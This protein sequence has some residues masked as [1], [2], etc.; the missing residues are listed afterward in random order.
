MSE[1]PEAKPLN[2]DKYANM[3]LQEFPF[4][5]LE[6]NYGEIETY[7]LDVI[8]S[9]EKTD[10]PS[11]VVIFIHGGGFLTLFNKRQGYVPKF[12]R[13][14]TEAGYVVISPD[15][16]SFNTVEDQDAAGGYPVA[17]DRAATAIHAA[18]KYIQQ[19][20]EALKLNTS[21]IAIMGGS[22][23][24]MTAFSAIAN[25]DDEYRLFVNCWGAPPVL[26]SLAG[27]PPVL[28]IH[29]TA[30]QSVDYSLEF[31]IQEALEALGIR[32]ELITLVDAKH[33]PTKRFPEY[34]P[35]ILSYLEDTMK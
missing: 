27:F 20:A 19:H 7:H 35:T 9:L 16:P 15:Y 31:P 14:L 32:H 6:N 30:D 12:A 5:E 21:R 11:P 24:G 34:I 18:Y 10:V 28:S 25:Y 3:D 26:P 8:S 13:A 22:A 17:A 1:L 2:V 33:T 23:G 4:A 29:G